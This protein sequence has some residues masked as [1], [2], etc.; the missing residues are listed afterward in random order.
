MTL[1][2]V[3]FEVGGKFPI[4]SF[5]YCGKKVDVTTTNLPNM[6]SINAFLLTMPHI[7]L[8]LAIAEYNISFSYICGRIFIIFNHSLPSWLHPQYSRFRIVLDMESFHFPLL[9]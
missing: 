1:S 7:L 2:A 9:V 6:S 4:K 5:M 3:I 8:Y